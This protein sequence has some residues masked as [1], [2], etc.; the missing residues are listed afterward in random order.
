MPVRLE[1]LEQLR[2]LGA[3]LLVRVRDH[4]ELNTHGTN[5][6]RA[7]FCSLRLMVG[8]EAWKVRRI[9]LHPR[10]TLRTSHRSKCCTPLP[11]R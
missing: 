7:D 4:M 6:V 10:V 3:H 5:S 9:R 1:R 8:E 2:D 11:P